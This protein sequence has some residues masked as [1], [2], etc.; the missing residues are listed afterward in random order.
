VES[1][2][3]IDGAEDVRLIGVDTPE[4]VDPDEEIEPYGPEASTFATS[5]LTGERV[6]LEFGQ[7]KFDDYDRLL[8][9]VYVDGQMFNE[10]LVEQGYAQAYPYST[11]HRGWARRR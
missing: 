10:E 6:D 4:T 1:S 9:Y 2:P 5:E 11:F 3:T 8:A 7:E